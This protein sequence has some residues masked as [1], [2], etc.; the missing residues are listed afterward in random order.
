MNLAGKIITGVV[1]T[2]VVAG[3]AYLWHEAKKKARSITETMDRYTQVMAK[4]NELKAE[5]DVTERD[6]K[7]YDHLLKE[8]QRYLTEADAI[9]YNAMVDNLWED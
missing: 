9:K 7:D 8:Y 4:A 6:H 2:G 3:A 5:L 1:I